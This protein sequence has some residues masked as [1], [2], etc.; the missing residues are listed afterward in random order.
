M[1][2]LTSGPVS[3]HLL[4]T[5]SFMLVTMIFQTLYFLVDL[6]WVGR[7]GKQAIAA[8]A[9]AGNLMFVV[10]AVTQMLGVGTTTLVSHASGRK[11]RAE[12]GLVFNQSQAL[13]V[14]CAAA[15]FLVA[16]MLQPAYV[17]TLCADPD[18]ARLA[19]AYLRYFIPALAM[20]FGLV[21]MGA[22]LRGTGNFKPGMVVGTASVIINMILAPFLIFGWVTGRPM[23]VAGAALASLIAVAI[24][25]VWLLVY[26]LRRDA[27]VTFAP[28]EWMP[29]MRVWGKLLGIGLPAGADF[30][31]MGV[32]LF[33]VYSVIR[34]FGSATQAGFGIGLRVIQSGFMPVVALGFAV[35]PVAG[36][37]FG[38]G[39]F[40]RVREAFRSAAVAAALVMLAFTALVQVAPAAMVGVF[41]ADPD[42]VRVGA[43]YM[44][45]TSWNFA[46]SGIV[47]ISSS[48]FQ[49]M[50]NT[51]PSLVTS[52][53]RIV[54]VS[55][56]VIALSR[57]PG[58]TPRWVWYLSVASVVLQ[59]AMNLLL[60][61]REFRLRLHV[62]G[63]A[64]EGEANPIGQPRGAN[65]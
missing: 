50:G 64:G 65:A 35:A 21:A 32:Y 39:R 25:S 45:I 57:L 60:L 43:E 62:G 53:T 52:F 16:T 44:R 24:G 7:L 42:V 49:A 8:V 15:F 27:F 40:E 23:G 5:T 9:I 38:A 56:P 1:Q 36:Q 33:V 51:I 26:F 61:R 28:A 47:F 58:F 55:I 22:A 29:R 13:A 34:P 59:M 17:R 10:L 4:K 30:A 19:T 18:T 63:R 14:A 11:D 54:V 31:L 37:N 12:A 41:S 20:Q 2:D 3:R 46:A 48:M 6:Y